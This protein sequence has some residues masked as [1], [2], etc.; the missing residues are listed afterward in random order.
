MGLTAGEVGGHIHIAPTDAGS[1]AGQFVDELGNPRPLAVAPSWWNGSS[2]DREYGPNVFKTLAAVSVTAGT[3]VAIWTPA[4][5]KKFRLIGFM[6]SLS[7]AGA[8][9]FKDGGNSN[10]EIFRTSLMGAGVGLASPWFGN[11]VLG[12][13]A[14]GALEIDVTSTG[15]VSGFVFGCEQ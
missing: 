3:P 14:N 1:A 8:I 4:A 9:I 12:F 11:G 13:A 6:L 5:G 10:A 7:V 2:L 15:T